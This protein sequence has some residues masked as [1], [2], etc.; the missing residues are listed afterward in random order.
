MK[1][2]KPAFQK[3]IFVC[4]NERQA[5]DCCSVMGQKLREALK[6][7]VN[8]KGLS[9]KI[10]VSRAGCL[11]VCSQGPNVLLMPDN[12]WFKE[13]TLEDI[14]NILKEAAPDGMA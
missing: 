7:S 13:V 14:P 10:C 4:E 11:D 8:E 12:V 3:Y 1:T 9:E 2:A 6:R 5:G